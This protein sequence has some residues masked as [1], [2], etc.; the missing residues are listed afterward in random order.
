MNRPESKEE[1]SLSRR[2][3]SSRGPRRLEGISDNFGKSQ[4]RSNSKKRSNS[5]KK[6]VNWTFKQEADV[7]T[8]NNLDELV[9]GNFQS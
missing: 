1:R 9:G 2:R 3:A 7:N 4:I 8:N 5:N 6:T